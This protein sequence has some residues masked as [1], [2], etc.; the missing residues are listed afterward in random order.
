M[1]ETNE[2]A[3]TRAATLRKVLIAAA[4][5]FAMTVVLI[6]VLVPGCRNQQAPPS[7]ET[8]APP[9]VQTAEA[10]RFCPVQPARMPFAKLDHDMWAYCV[11]FN[12]DGTDGKPSKTHLSKGTLLLDPE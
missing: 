7:A 1:E 3:K 2:Q 5:A 6:V 8:P 10:S 4:C 11:F 9:P 12:K